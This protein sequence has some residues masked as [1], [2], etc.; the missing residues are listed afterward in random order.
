MVN[1]AGV[2]VT[3][4]N[5]SRPGEAVQVGDSVSVSFEGL[6]QPVQKMTAIYNP[7]F[8]STVWVQYNTSAGS[9]VQSQGVQYSVIV[10]NTIEFIAEEPGE[11]KLVNGCIH[12]GHLG[13][14]L[15]THREIPEEG[16]PPNFNASA[17]TNS[18]YFSTLP[19]ITIQV[20]GSQTAAE[21][22]RFNYAQ[23]T[24]ESWFI[25]VLY[26]DCSPGLRQLG[27]PEQLAQ[28]FLLSRSGR[29]LYHT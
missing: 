3:A 4:V 25:P 1:A 17:G 29:Q 8:P 2:V 22:S 7:G 23:L 20:E 18:P 9:L 28:H 27:G 11:F 12:S 13:S 15:D 16:L 10:D 6:K 19:D 24:P 5:N 26:P 21:Q 14:P